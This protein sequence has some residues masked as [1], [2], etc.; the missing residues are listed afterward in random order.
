MRQTVSVNAPP[1]PPTQCCTSLRLR[2]NS[3]HA[4]TCSAPTDS[5]LELPTSTTYVPLHVPS[6]VT[7]TVGTFPC[8]VIGIAEPGPECA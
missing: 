5:T 2:L 4:F 6:S 8:S 1:I 7:S 3:A